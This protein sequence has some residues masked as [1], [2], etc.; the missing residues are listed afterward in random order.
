M[1]GLSCRR[2]SNSACSVFVKNERNRVWLVERLDRKA[3]PCS[4]LAIARAMIFESD[5]IKSRQ[6]LKVEK[7]NCQFG[8][9][10]RYCCRKFFI[11]GLYLV[12]CN[13]RNR[14]LPELVS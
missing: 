2:I 8:C 5:L 7:C 4:A 9:T 6:K 10:A 1:Q 14:V 11:C 3:S 13:G 12:K